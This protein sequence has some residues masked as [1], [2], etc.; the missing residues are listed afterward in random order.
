MSPWNLHERSALL[1]ADKA[2]PD[3]QRSSAV[4]GWPE[5]TVSICWK[6]PRPA[7]ANLHDEALG[8]DDVNDPMPPR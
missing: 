6:D 5:A 8:Q 7:S 1:W 2:L 3:W 4:G